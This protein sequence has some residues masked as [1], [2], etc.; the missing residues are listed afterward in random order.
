MSGFST[1]AEHGRRLLEQVK[2]DLTVRLLARVLTARMSDAIVDLRHLA[3]ELP[4]E[5]RHLQPTRED[6]LQRLTF[7]LPAAEAA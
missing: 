5:V 7:L 6:S 1:G 4:A 3:E 2:A